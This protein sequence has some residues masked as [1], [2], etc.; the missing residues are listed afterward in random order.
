MRK[1]LAA[2]L[3]FSAAALA[4]IGAIQGERIRPHVKILSS[5]LFE[6]RGVGQ[7]GGAL[8][9]EYIE[10]QFAAAGLKPGAADGTYRQ[11]VPL[12]LIAMEG[13]PV[14]TMSIGAQ[15]VEL[16]W[17]DEFVGHSQ[18]QQ[19]SVAV[20][21]EMIFAGHGIS[22]PEFG[23]D[24]YAGTDVKGKAVVLFTNEPPSDDTKFFGGRA[25]TYYGRWTYKYEE[26][27]RRGAAAVLIV[28]T[29][30]TAGYGYQVVKAN[31]R[32]QP[33]VGRAEGAY[34]LGFAGW[35][36]QGS[37]ERLFA[38]TGNTVEAM[39][40]K[41]NTKGFKPIPLGMR[42]KLDLVNKVDDVE[43]YN[44][45]G[46]IDGSDPESSKEAVVYTA[47]WDHLGVGDPVNGDTIYNGALD[48]ATGCAMLIEMARAWASMEPKPRRS[49]L[50][51]A[52]T[53]EES[54]LLGSAYLA[55]NPPVPAAKLAADLNFDSFS[56]LGR[57]K[58]SVM[59]GA[60]RT[61]FF[62]VVQAAAARHQLA[63]EKEGN[64]G[65]GGYFRS[66]HFSFAKQG[67]PAFSVGMGA[68]AAAQLPGA[69][70]A[71]SERMKGIYHQPSDQYYDDWDFSGLEQFA[72]FGMALGL[73]I[74][75]LPELPAR[76]KP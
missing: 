65:A 56:P 4:Q 21:A 43:T 47:H 42:M 11:R 5:D 46:R 2:G 41:A 18:R 57:A 38:M 64:P 9:V 29:D 35:I 31:G 27:T 50:F 44:V 63:I 32:P 74:A 15:K 62:G 71:V 66:D 17:L 16:K 52:V 8:A 36:T 24:D 20:D 76:I 58:S 6:G 12:K 68:R 75:N 59:T 33:Q 14:L 51:A 13:S 73:D 40:A 3:L 54:G 72:R 39:L 19:P 48:N 25:L 7:R 30:A 45:V 70:N 69:L 10:S 22:A 23:W 49:V 26:A 55:Q 53:A 67:V 1:A 34:A 60:D 28:H 37:A 61:S